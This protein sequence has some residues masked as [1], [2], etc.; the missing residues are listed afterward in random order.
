MQ[1]NIYMR[2]DWRRLRKLFLR[3]HPLCVLCRAAPAVHVDH[4]EPITPENWNVIGLKESNLQSLCLRCH[5]RKTAK[6]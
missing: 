1:K 5:N 2:P 3:E 4:I 6:Q